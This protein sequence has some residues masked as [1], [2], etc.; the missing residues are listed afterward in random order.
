M[1]NPEDGQHW[2]PDTSNGINPVIVVRF[3]AHNVFLQQVSLGTLKVKL[4]ESQ[5]ILKD[6]CGINRVD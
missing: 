1:E 4:F 3:S 2:T 5:L 6:H